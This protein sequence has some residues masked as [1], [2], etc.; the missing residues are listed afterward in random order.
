[1]NGGRLVICNLQKTP[2]DH[3]ATL[4]I[5]AK[6]DDIMKLLMQKL[7]YQIPTWQMKKRIEVSLVEQGSKVQLRGI[8]DTRQPF[9]LFEKIEV[10]GLSA[11]TSKT[12][13][14]A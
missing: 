13:P 11:N 2:L 8:D 4:V 1:M 7:S 14:S 6:C 3:L 10:L 5:H 12:F 9:H